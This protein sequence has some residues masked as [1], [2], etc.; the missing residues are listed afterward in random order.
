HGFVD[1]AHPLATG[2]N[3]EQHMA[4]LPERGTYTRDMIDAALP[5]R[6]Q[7]VLPT[8]Y[9]ETIGAMIDAGLGWSVLPEGLKRDNWVRIPMP[10]MTR[11]LG[12][13]HDPKRHLGVSARGFLAALDSAANTA[14]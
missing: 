3:P 4:I 8:N 12:V 6:L 2:G 9:L 1:Q 11:T 13:I 10:A 7:Q 14:R 5:F